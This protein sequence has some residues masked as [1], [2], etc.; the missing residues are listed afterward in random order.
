MGR[1]D[2][3]QRF[4]APTV[5]IG[6]ALVYLFFGFSQLIDP[7]R[8][9]GWL[10]A[11]A[12]ILPVSATTLILA[13]GVLEVTLGLLLI[14]GIYTRLSAA[15][16]GLHLLAIS[17]SMGFTETAVRDF[18]LALA[19]LSVALTGPDVLCLDRKFTK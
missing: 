11:E 8:F 16:L 9:T 5:R 18:G 7:A 10:P 4:G 3:L 14:A 6:I 17:T 13:N 1:L 15:V 19:T 2:S 12:A